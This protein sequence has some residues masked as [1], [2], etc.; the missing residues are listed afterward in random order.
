MPFEDLRAQAFVEKGTGAGM[1]AHRLHK[2][3]G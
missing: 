3:C 1:M 2:P